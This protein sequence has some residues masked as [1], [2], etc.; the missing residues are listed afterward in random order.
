MGTRI[1]LIA[2]FTYKR[3]WDRSFVPAA[4]KNIYSGSERIPFGGKTK[5]GGRNIFLPIPVTR[6]PRNAHPSKEKSKTL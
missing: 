5:L 4:M 3:Q 2:S 1:S 6:N